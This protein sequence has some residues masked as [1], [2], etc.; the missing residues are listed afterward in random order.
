[1]GVFH[2]F[3]IVQMVPNPA[4]CL[5]SFEEIH[6]RSK[7]VAVQKQFINMTKI[8]MNLIVACTWTRSIL[9]IHM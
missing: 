3:E 9:D 8:L 5:I 7:S 2:V 4:K 6:K 1:M